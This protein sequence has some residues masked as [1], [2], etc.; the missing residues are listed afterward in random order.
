MKMKLFQIV[1]KQL[2]FLGFVPNQQKT[3]NKKFS[4]HHTIGLFLAAFCISQMAVYLFYVAKSTN[5][6]M[7]SFFTL[8]VTVSV[9]LSQTSLVYKNDKIFNIIDTLEKMLNESEFQL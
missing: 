3:S 5:E 6:Y 4:K 8:M 7:N 9:L 1:R 2:T